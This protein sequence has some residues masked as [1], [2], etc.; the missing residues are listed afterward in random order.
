MSR[1][2]FV[3]ALRRAVGKPYRWGGQKLTE[4]FDCSGLVIWAFSEIGWRIKDTNAM[5][6]MEEFHRNKVLQPASTP[7]TL[8]FYGKTVNTVDHVMIVLEKWN[9]D[10]F[11]LVGARGGNSAVTNDI[12]AYGKKAFVDVVH[13]S[14]W[15][16]KFQQA[17]DPFR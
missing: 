12:K 6:L 1:E 8:W 10:Q 14:Y 3:R 15:A 11:I 16:N 2:D 5:G 7:G 9:D 4:G 17:L 13:G